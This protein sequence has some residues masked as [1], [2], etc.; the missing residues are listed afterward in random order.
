M[1]QDGGETDRTTTHRAMYG[2][3]ID[4][5]R[6]DDRSVERECDVDIPTESKFA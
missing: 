1:M 4:I 2:R 5:C 6:P 3:L